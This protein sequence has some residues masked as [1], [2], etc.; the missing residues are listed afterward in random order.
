M[1][2]VLSIRKCC[3]RFSSSAN[4]FKFAIV[5]F[6]V[7]ILGTLLLFKFGDTIGVF[8]DSLASTNALTQKKMQ[9]VT[10]YHCFFS[11]SLTHS[12]ANTLTGSN[13]SAVLATPGRSIPI[14]TISAIAI[15]TAVYV[16]VVWMFGCTISNEKLKNEKLI[17]ALVAWPHK[18]PV[19]LGIIMSCVGA[20]LQSLT[21]A[22]RLL[23]AIA[24]DNTIP[25]LNG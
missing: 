3:L 12:H 5:L 7:M 17:V 1:D 24:K 15:T 2:F 16:S 25:F 10:V 9:T 18:V 6:I 22:P 4:G 19:N 14:G 13:R 8:S 23:S 21:G 11:H 20:G